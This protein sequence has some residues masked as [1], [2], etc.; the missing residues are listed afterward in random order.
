MSNNNNFFNR[1]LCKPSQEPVS[2]GVSFFADNQ[3]N[4]GT[5]NIK[6]GVAVCG[7]IER[8]VDQLIGTLG[9]MTNLKW[10][11]EDPRATVLACVMQEL[12]VKLKSDL[13]KEHQPTFR[14]VVGG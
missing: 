11:G 8:Q 12:L 1:E 3:K 13:K 9:K 4:S 10:Q 14:R 6:T 2:A 7:D 5:E